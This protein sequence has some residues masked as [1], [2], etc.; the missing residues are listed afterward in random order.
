MVDGVQA[1]PIRVKLNIGSM[2]WIISVF[3]LQYL[4]ES[5]GLLQHMNKGKNNIYITMF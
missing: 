3:C 5:Y 2:R 1:T 4:K